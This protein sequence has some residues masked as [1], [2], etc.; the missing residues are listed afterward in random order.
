M[1]TIRSM[2]SV[3]TPGL[4][5]A[6]ALSRMVRAMWHA[7]REPSICFAV[8][9]G[10]AHHMQIRAV[11]VPNF[12]RLRV[13]NNLGNVCA[14]QSAVNPPMLCCLLSISLYGMPVSA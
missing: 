13:G 9:I 7:L 6:C 4:M 11:P 5:A 1:R 2:S 8:L 3:V 10:T 14:Q 12:W